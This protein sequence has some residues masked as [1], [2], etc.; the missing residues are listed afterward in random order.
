MEMYIKKAII[1][2]RIGHTICIV[3]RQ[4]SA[5]MKAKYVQFQIRNVVCGFPSTL[6][7]Y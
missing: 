4:P 6:P 1:R 3:I 7:E 2:S 5:L